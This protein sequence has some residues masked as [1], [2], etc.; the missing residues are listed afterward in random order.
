MDGFL[1][2]IESMFNRVDYSRDHIVNYAVYEVPDSEKDALYE[3]IK[4]CVSE[5][6]D[7]DII[8]LS[9]NAFPSADA[10]RSRISELSR[11]SNKGI[12]MVDDINTSDIALFNTFRYYL[13]EPESSGFP[14]GWL[15]LSL[16]DE[17]SIELFDDGISCAV[18]NWSYISY[19]KDG[20]KSI[21]SHLLSLKKI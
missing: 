20:G 11:I 18:S 13:K 19:M 5:V 2:F 1:L 9:L 12:L 6:K 4:H 7:Y 8:R 21:A 17:K 14:A 16:W 15:I 10:F 3:F